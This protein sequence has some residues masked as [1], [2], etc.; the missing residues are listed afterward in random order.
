MKKGKVTM[1]ITLG[2]ICFV[3]VFVMFMQFKT[4]EQT[5]IT[6]IETMRETELKDALADW[7][8]KYQETNESLT[9]T[10]QKNEEYKQK[11]DSNQ[12]ANELLTK[13]VSQTNLMSGKV[14]VQGE[15][16]IITLTDTDEKSVASLDLVNL[17]NELVLAGA[18]AISI[19]D[20]RV[21]NMT[22]IVDIGNQFIV[23]NSQ[24]ISSPYII[25]AIGEKMY[26]QSAL[27]IKSGFVDRIKASGINVSIDIKNNVKILKYD[28]DKSNFK[29][30]K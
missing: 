14:D 25:K 21:V 20:N 6:Q 11:D 12:E 15:G 27:T 2:I 13:E 4:V 3:L 23:I 28:G 22:D 19:N 7:K 10:R 16:I 1:T 5:D 26:L 9:Q 30:V 17:V 18:E 8:I 24:R 29:Y